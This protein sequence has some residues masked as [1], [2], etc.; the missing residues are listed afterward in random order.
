MEEEGPQGSPTPALEARGE[1]GMGA[2]PCLTPDA[3]PQSLK[4]GCSFTS[5]S[6]TSY[7]SVVPKPNREPHKGTPREKY[8]GELQF[9]LSEVGAVLSH[10][11]G[12]LGFWPIQVCEATKD[13]TDTG[14]YGL[15][16]QLHST[17]AQETCG[18]NSISRKSDS[19]RC[20]T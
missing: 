15:C 14:K 2:A 8:S 1:Q 10:Q 20:D 6:G 3:S 17:L 18:K 11:K 16:H 9:Q 19:P 12:N 5:T 7:T 4:T 13:W